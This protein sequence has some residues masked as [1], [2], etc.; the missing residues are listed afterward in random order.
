MGMMSKVLRQCRKPTGWLGRLTAR[1]MNRSH[2][3]QTDWG[4]HHISVESHS[5][6]L[7]IGCGGGGTVRKLAKIAT[8]GKVHGIDY[9]DESVRVSGN[10]NRRLIDTGRVEIRPVS[11]S[12]MPFSDGTFDL[13]TAV[14]THHFW[15]D[16]ANDL[17]E[18]LRVL[19]PGGVLMIVG[20]EYKG[21][22][23]HE[24]DAKWAEQGG[25]T[26]HTRDEL[27]ELLSGVGYS[28]VRV[29]EQYDEGWICAVGS[30]PAPTPGAS[31][32]AT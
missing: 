20:G 14:E 1:G 15:P 23:Y 16:L 28:Q 5:T 26:Y 25:M 2:S 13:V 4:L 21:G 3:R 11:V 9:S 24:R 29:F 7:D 32:L 12:E 17:R 18:V 30:K 10:T 6:I 31:G 27:A 19:K 8:E 22:R